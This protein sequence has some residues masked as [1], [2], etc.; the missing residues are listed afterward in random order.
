MRT[1]FPL[2]HA[3]KKDAKRDPSLRCSPDVGAAGGG[4]GV[5]LTDR[6]CKNKKVVDASR[7]LNLV[8]SVIMIESRAELFDGDNVAIGWEKLLIR[9]LNFIMPI[10]VNR[11][12]C[13]GRRC[14]FDKG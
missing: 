5:S 1:T 2:C 13:Q 12:L 9:D 8:L 11:E 3:N 10:A 7:A 4:V 14:R 6:W